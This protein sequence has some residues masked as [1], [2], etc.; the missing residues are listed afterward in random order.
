MTVQEIKKKLSLARYAAT[1]LERDIERLQVLRSQVERIT[2][3]IS[4]MPR[5]GG[6]IDRRGK[7]LAELVDISREYEEDCVRQQRA[8]LEVQRLIDRAEK[9]LWRTVLEGFY[10]DGLSWQRIADKEGYS[11][12][13]VTNAH[14]EALLFLANSEK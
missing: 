8:I 5:G 11:Y 1:R 6:E 4:D 3:V 9:P 12:S 13:Y 2:S 14:G 7:L 10:I